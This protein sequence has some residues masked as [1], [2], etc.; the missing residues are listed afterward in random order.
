MSFH[1]GGSH[2][3]KRGDGGTGYEGAKVQHRFGGNLGIAFLEIAS[4]RHDD[5]VTPGK[6]LEKVSRAALTMQADV[7]G[8]RND[9]AAFAAN[10]ERVSIAKLAHDLD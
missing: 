10:V 9:E 8:L 4:S 3:L 7:V 6:A 2:V 5:S 1:R